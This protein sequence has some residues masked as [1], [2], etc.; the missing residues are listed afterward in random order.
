MSA[1]CCLGRWRLAKTKMTSWLIR[2]APRAPGGVFFEEMEKRCG[3]CCYSSKTDVFENSWRVLWGSSSLF[4][5][6]SEC[7]YDLWVCHPKEVL[8]KEVF[9]VSLW[10]LPWWHP[11]RAVKKRF[12]SL[13]KSWNKSL[14]QTPK[15][16][17]PKKLRKQQHSMSH[18]P[19][20]N[21]CE[22]CANSANW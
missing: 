4:G 20:F 16:F 15:H 21:P 18:Q 17:V 19:P 22:S 9:V 11:F 5:N 1:F 13:E 8:S 3:F 7:W 6:K 12:L 10:G 2:W 14:R